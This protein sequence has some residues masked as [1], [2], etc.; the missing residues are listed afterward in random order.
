ML[1][2]II[3]HWWKLRTKKKNVRRLLQRY[4]RDRKRVKGRHDRYTYG[5]DRAALYL[6]LESAK[7]ANKRWEYG[8]GAYRKG[9][10]YTDG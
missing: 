1:S 5:Y 6:S 3:K 10:S 8:D 4:E 9:S 2:C 7:V